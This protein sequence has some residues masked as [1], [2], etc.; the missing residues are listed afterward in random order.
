MSDWQHERKSQRAENV[1]SPLIFRKNFRIWGKSNINAK[2]DSP[3]FSSQ[4]KTSEHPAVPESRELTH[5]G[6]QEFP[7]TPVGK[8][9]KISKGK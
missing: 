9:I 7:V 2:D 8:L 3:W 6:I 4:S 1:F 5:S